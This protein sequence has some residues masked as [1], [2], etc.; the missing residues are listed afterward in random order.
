MQ[1][2]KKKRIGFKPI[3]I[4]STLIELV[5]GNLITL[6]V[7]YVCQTTLEEKHK[8]VV[9]KVNLLDRTVII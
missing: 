1:N 6:E 2:I 3:N 5:F 9:I 7:D 4:L 8:I